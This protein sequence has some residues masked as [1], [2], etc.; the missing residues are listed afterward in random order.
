MLRKTDPHMRL[1][2][3]DFEWRGTDV[4]R[5]ENLSDIVFAIAFG[6]VVSAATLPRTYSELIA[7]LVG[8]LPVAAGF[9]VLISVWHYHYKFFRRIGS[10]TPTILWL[11]GALLFTVLYLA[12]PLRFSFEGLFAFMMSANGDFTR[13]DQLQVGWERSGHIMGFFAA[14]YAVLHLVFGGLYAH[15][16]R[17]SPQLSLTAREHALVREDRRFHIWA[18]IL[19][20]FVGVIA[21]FTPLNGMAGFGFCLFGLIG[22]LSARA[23]ARAATPPPA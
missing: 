2:D 17:L 12:Y 11:N 18:G 20:I 21:V 7:V 15:A 16:A 9:A 19:C 14:G 22:W 1:Y 3:P 8:V 6:F 23:E 13:L 10:V 4:S 5:I